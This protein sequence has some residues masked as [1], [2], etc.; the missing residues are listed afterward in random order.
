MNTASNT[1]DASRAVRWIGFASLG[2]ALVTVGSAVL[3]YWPGHAD[4]SLFRTYLS[5]IGDTPGWPQILFNNGTIMA[6]PLRLLFLALFLF[7]LRNYSGRKPVFEAITFSLGVVSATGTVFMTAVPYSTGPAV[8][9]LG[10]FLYFLTVVF[11][12]S[13]I[14]IQE[15]KVKSL[16]RALPAL[17]F[18]VVACFLVFFVLV[19]LFQGGIVSRST[20]VFWEWL[21]YLS[22]LFWLLGNTLVLGKR[23][24][25]MDSRTSG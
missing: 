22:S 5:D 21:C 7:M 15:L 11:M 1:M 6:A 18:F 2:L 17:S 4:F 3:A 19:M 10:I 13:I 20:P 25:W 24:K 16:P 8:H 14:G 9:E 23:I 12:Q